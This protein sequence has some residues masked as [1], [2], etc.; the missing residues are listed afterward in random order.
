MDPA[1][2]TEKQKNYLTLLGLILLLA[3]G[4]WLRCSR[5]DVFAP[6][7]DELMHLRIAEGRN[8]GEVWHFSLLETHPPLGH[9]FRYAWNLVFHPRD[10]VGARLPSALLGVLAI[11]V[12]FG[13]GREV[14][15]RRGGLLA[16]FIA[17][18][19][20]LPIVQS[21]LV[22]NYAL[23]MVLIGLMF[24]AFLRLRKRWSWRGLAVYGLC[25]LLSVLTHFGGV[26][27]TVSSL[28]VLAR[29]L[30]R[31]GRPGDRWKRLIPWIVVNGGILLVVA[32]QCLIQRPYLEPMTSVATRFD[33]LSSWRLL[34]TME[35]FLM[36][37]PEP[38]LAM[39]FLFVLGLVGQRGR[40]DI[41]EVTKH[42]LWVLLGA[43]GLAIFLGVAGIYPL[44]QYLRR[45]LWLMAPVSAFLASLFSNPERG[46]RDVGHPGFRLMEEL[47]TW[48]G[49][50]TAGFLFTIL[51]ALFWT[52]VVDGPTKVQEDRQ[53]FS[54]TQKTLLDVRNYLETSLRPGDIVIADFHVA[55]YFFEGEHNLY[56]ERWNHLGTDAVVSMPVGQG[57]ML[58]QP[59]R[60][61][62]RSSAEFRELARAAL[63]AGPHPPGYRVFLINWAL[64]NPAQQHLFQKEVDAHFGKE[65]RYFRNLPDDKSDKP[66]AAVFPFDGEFFATQVL[67]LDGAHAA[68]LGQE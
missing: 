66:E 36:P 55:I 28:V 18:L 7:V 26:I 11:P 45:H 62:V 61:Y 53:E 41:S 65:V 16:A 56:I 48:Q 8:L 47:R 46:E 43:C 24:W 15:G 39:V 42:L 63:A 50:V 9:F 64:T 27:L 21:T 20:Y 3:A 1:T 29:D 2:F 40:G 30:W 12:Y 5:L 23:F 52:T 35:A 68:D 67:P 4:G 6:N 31:T 32:G 13:L 33:F 34:Q 14:G 54:L 37:K 44:D 22:R 58:T 10:I 38:A 49:L 60:R 17:A 51:A 57:T 59:N 19:G 25:A